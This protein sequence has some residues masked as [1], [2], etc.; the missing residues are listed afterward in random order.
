MKFLLRIILILLVL[1]GCSQAPINANKRTLAALAPEVP[2]IPKNIQKE[3]AGEILAK[4]CPALNQ[5]INLC[6]VTR[7]QARLLH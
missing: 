7:D 5:I 1:G 6:L 4:T 3:A 2:P